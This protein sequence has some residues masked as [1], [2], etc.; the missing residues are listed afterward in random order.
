MRCL[1]IKTKGPP[2]QKKAS[3]FQAGTRGLRTSLAKQNS[4]LRSTLVPIELNDSFQAVFGA[5]SGESKLYLR[6]STAKTE[7]ARAQEV[8]FARR[9]GLPGF[10]EFLR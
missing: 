9:N 8:R 1:R 7:L 10:T 6:L 5:G 4:S 2:G 3:Q